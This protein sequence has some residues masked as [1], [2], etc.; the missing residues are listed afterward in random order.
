MKFLVTGGCGFIGSH[1]IDRL[2]ARGDEVVAF[3]DLSTGRLSNLAHHEGHP[4]LEIVVDDIC[5]ASALESHAASCD[6]ILHLA[7]AVGVRLI[8]ERPVQT[9]VTNVRGTEV[10]LE[11]ASH[12][13]RP[14]FVASTSEVYGKLMDHDEIDLLREDGDWRLGPTTRRRW[15]YACS[16]ALDEF[17]ALAYVDEHR[18]PAVIGRFFNT[19]GPRQTGR[20][21]MVLP[22]FAR[23]AILGEPMAVHGDGR[24]S[25]CFTHVDDSVQAM[26]ALVDSAIAGVREVIGGVFNIGSSSEVSM[27]ELAER[28][29][30][31]A[32]SP[33]LIELVPYDQVYGAG[34]EDMR[35]RTPDLARIHGAVG[36][37]PQHGLESII[38]DVLEDQ[39]R[40]IARGD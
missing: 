12:H 20:Y 29:K 16:K 22:K 37:Q 9:I 6:A 18:L 17:L 38:T 3:D 23:A 24:Q 26:L 32:G 36:W 10:V 13:R 5:D 30:A 27:L 28:V 33:S 15:A 11:A 7:A 2:L 25:R 39:R 4:R 35:R 21:G 19:V 8:M 34:F 14:I 31:A 40:R 1:A